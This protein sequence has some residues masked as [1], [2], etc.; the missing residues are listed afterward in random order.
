MTWKI[1][2]NIVIVDGK[3]EFEYLPR[4]ITVM[5]I[6]TVSLGYLNSPAFYC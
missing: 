3:D 5:A 4:V 1:K 6:V 2:D